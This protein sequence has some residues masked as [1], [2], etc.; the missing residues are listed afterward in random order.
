MTKRHYVFCYKD[1]YNLWVWGWVGDT[2]SG[3][4]VYDIFFWSGSGCGSVS[5][6]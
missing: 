3:V 4:F 2:G 6:G 5:I 1:R